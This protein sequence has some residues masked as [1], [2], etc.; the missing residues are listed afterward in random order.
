MFYVN[1]F[2]TDLKSDILFGLKIEGS[3]ISVWLVWKTIAT[4]YLV[5][6]WDVWFC[7]LDFVTLD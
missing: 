1:T 7:L 5:N 2:E 6:D 3:A 4:E